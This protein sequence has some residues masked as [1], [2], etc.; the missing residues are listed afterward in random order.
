[1]T[2][3]NAQTLDLVNP[4]V[5]REKLGIDSLESGLLELIAA[6]TDRVEALE[7]LVDQLQAQVDAL[8]TGG[9]GGGASTYIPI[10]GGDG[11]TYNLSIPLVEGVPTLDWNP[12]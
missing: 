6:L 7:T 10:L 9:T 11:I 5:W 3:L 4:A 1:M 2:R 12:A 8:P